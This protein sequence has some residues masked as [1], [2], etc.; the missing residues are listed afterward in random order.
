M[1]YSVL[2]ALMEWSSIYYL[3]DQDGKLIS[4]EY[5]QY[6]TDYFDPEVKL[7]KPVNNTIHIYLYIS[8]EELK[9]NYEQYC[10]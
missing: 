3:L 10:K 2:V 4:G 5:R 7:F 9:K 6:L 8:L 1:K